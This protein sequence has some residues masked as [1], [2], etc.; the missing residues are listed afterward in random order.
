MIEK[1]NVEWKSVWKDDY[2]AW[3]CG[4][5]N[6][7][8][9]SL[10]IGVDDSGKPIGLRNGRKLL[11]DL[12]NKIR[13]AL[14]ITV[15]VDLHEGPP[16][17]IVIEVPSYSIPISC[18][19][20]YYYRSGA[21]NQR[22][23]GAELESFILRR[24]GV[25]WDS[26]PVPHANLSDIDEL[27]VRDFCKNAVKK[28]RLD[29]SVLSEPLDEIIGRLR[30]KNGEYLTN[31]ALLLFGSEADRW[32]SSAYVKVGF[33]ET[34]ADLI[35]QDEIRGPLFQ[36]ADKTLEL[37]YF[38]YLKAKISYEGIL[39]EERYPY[40]KE[41]LRE[42]L[43]NAI[44]HKDYASGIPIQISVYDDR[45]YIGNIGRLPESWTIENLMGKHV[46]KPFNP[47][48][49]NAFYL[50][51]YI[52]SWG[53]GVEK[54]CRACEADGITHPQYTVNPSDIM[55]KFTAPEDRIVRLNDSPPSNGFTEKFTESFTE[56]F[57]E[58]TEN[59]WE[60]LKFLNE[61]PRYTT[62]ELAARL[63]VS[64]QTVSKRIKILKGKGLIE[65]EGSDT[66]GSWKVKTL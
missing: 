17:Y 59:E 11:E 39:R 15:N 38:K 44:V 37:V 41:A 22:L 55:I 52:E 16:D 3:I 13:D 49:A 20:A 29:E 25:N 47:T 2:L 18:K 27:L 56:K 53:R 9:G 14:G 66:K 48:I 12:P 34:D 32:F 42:A 54:I 46:S 40:P 61:N 21:T 1:Q 7:Q 19:G 63:S 4:F 30:L 24:R 50:A 36:Q 5:A 57:T 65:R 62:A 23:T 45:L 26:S 35:Y 8:G 6:A 28:G 31:A 58:V 64:R 10:Y 43:L 60:L 51:G 33:F